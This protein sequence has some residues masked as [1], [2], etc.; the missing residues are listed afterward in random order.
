M[1]AIA[2]YCHIRKMHGQTDNQTNVAL[3][4]NCIKNEW[5]DRWMKCYDCI[6]MI[7]PGF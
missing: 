4:L 5:M 1:C 2:D 6:A 3:I 7:N